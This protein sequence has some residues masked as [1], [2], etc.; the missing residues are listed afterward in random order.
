MAASHIS[1]GGVSN[2]ISRET[3]LMSHDD[4]GQLAI[5]LARAPARVA[6]EQPG[7]G[8]RRAFDEPPEQLTR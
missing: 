2:T 5:E 1:A 7:L 6:H 4:C 8:N 3:S